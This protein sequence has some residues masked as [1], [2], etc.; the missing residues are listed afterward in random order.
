ML[1]SINGPQNNIVNAVEFSYGTW[2]ELRFHL[3]N[4]A[5]QIVS[6][7]DNPEEDAHYPEVWISYDLKIPSNYFHRSSSSMKNNKGFASLWQGHY[8]PEVKLQGIIEW[9]PTPSGNSELSLNIHGHKRNFDFVDLRYKS[10]HHNPEGSLAFLPE[11]FGKWVNVGLHWKAP[12]AH[13]AKD[14]IFEF[15]VDGQLK[16][17]MTGVD[18]QKRNPQTSG[19]IGFNKGYIL[20]YHNSGYEE[21]TIF[22]VTNFRIGTAKLGVID[23]IVSPPVAPAGFTTNN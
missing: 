16:A 9:W 10:L 17:R 1:A 19:P 14:G 6:E 23:E 11:Q 15:Y 7:Y 2:Q 3:T 22:Y 20:G 21:Q 5:D 12:T 13:G 4:K 18:Y 8:S